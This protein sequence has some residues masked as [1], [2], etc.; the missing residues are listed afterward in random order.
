MKLHNPFI[1]KGS[2]KSARSKKA[3][4]KAGGAGC[5]FRIWGTH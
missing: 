1:D 2:Y 3:L 4:A 5:P